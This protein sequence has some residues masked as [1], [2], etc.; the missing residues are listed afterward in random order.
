MAVYRLHILRHIDLFFVNSIYIYY[1]CIC[2]VIVVFKGIY[3]QA[4][5]GLQ[6]VTLKTSSSN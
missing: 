4:D 6:N 5:R 2:I 3:S 1:I